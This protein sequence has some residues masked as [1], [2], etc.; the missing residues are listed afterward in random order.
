MFRKKEN[1]AGWTGCG[2]L[3]GSHWGSILGNAKNRNIEINLTINEAWEKFLKQKRK[4][5]LT[6]VELTLDKAGKRYGRTASLD[7]IKSNLPY[8]KDNIQWI[9]KNVNYIKR[10]LDEDTF[11]ELCHSIS[12][13]NA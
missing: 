11:I 5:A 10:D 1:H 9:H 3:T 7:R 8:T 13:F 6:G 4:C 2:E 12:R